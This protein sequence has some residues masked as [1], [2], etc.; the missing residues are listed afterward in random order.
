MKDI[1]KL[2]AVVATIVAIK[3]IATGQRA[4]I[5]FGPFCACGYR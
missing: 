5:C 3:R 4:C 1:A 2:L